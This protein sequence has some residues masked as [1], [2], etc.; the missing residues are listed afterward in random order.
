MTRLMNRSHATP[1][2][3]GKLDI[4]MQIAE[5]TGQVGFIKR[6]NDELKAELMKRKLKDEEEEKERK[7]MAN[8]ER[9]KKRRIGF[10]FEIG[11]TI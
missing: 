1:R 3:V 7:E 11:F 8:D 4:L 2:S 6:E 9:R 10:Y 5:I